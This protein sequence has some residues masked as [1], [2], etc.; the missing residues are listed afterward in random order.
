MAYLRTSRASSALTD[1]AA[2]TGCCLP[3]AKFAGSPLLRD[4]QKILER[5]AVSYRIGYPL[6]LQATYLLALW[7]EVRAG[8][9]PRSTFD[10]ELPA[11]QAD[12]HHWLLMG[13]ECSSPKTL[14][15]CRNLLTLC[16]FTRHPG[17]EPTN[18]RAER[19]LWH[20]IIWR[21]L[22]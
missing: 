3:V 4:F 8:K 10:A 17:V 14:E 12:I 1:T 9:S 7:A 16:S 21:R 6:Q 19:A 18:T 20:P 15:T 11:I 22:S 5:D 2:T 13:A